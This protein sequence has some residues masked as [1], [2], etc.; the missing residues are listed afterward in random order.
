MIT[1]LYVYK[2]HFFAMHIYY[3][4]LRSYGRMFAIYNAKLFFFI[5]CIVIGLIDSANLQGAKNKIIEQCDLILIIR[6]PKNVT[7]QPQM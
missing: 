1:F 4:F 3:G 2:V 5:F 6:S 7:L